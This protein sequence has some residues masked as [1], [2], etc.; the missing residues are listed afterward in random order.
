MED[1]LDITPPDPYS[2]E[3]RNAA[4][5]RL[6][7]SRFFLVFGVASYLGSHENPLPAIL[8]T[9]SNPEL[10][11]KVVYLESAGETSF[12]SSEKGRLLLQLGSR[13]PP[14]S[15]VAK[16]RRV[17]DAIGFLFTYLSHTVWGDLRPYQ[18][19]KEFIT[20]T[21]V[22]V[23]LL[24]GL[25]ALTGTDPSPNKFLSDLNSFFTIAPE[26]TAAVFYLLPFVLQHEDLFNA[27]AFFRSCCSD[28]SFMGDAVRDVV[29]QP[30]WGPENEIQ[31]LALENVVLHSFRTIEA[32]VGEP[33]KRE[34]FHQRLRK[35]NLS[36][37]ER[38][39]FSGRRKHT[40]EN[41][42][43]WL[44]KARDSAA[45]HGKRRRHRP[46]TLLE[47]AE[48]QHLASTVLDRAL[49]TKAES[50]G[51]KG[52]ESEVAFLLEEMLPNNPGW[53]K[54]KKLFKGKRAVDL[55]RTPGGLAKVMRY[56]NRQIDA[57]FRVR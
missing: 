56:R 47:A 17:V 57:I 55:A 14:K 20:G 22:S 7:K 43:H 2:P 53:T 27:C 35:W 38:V 15:R 4:R 13:I 18:I 24:E 42:I 16:A 40:L 31:R 9:C 44:Q 51:R 6:S 11:L 48:A 52:D 8:T 41:R 49:W 36:P 34:L 29:D 19:P 33:G 10:A 5:L 50:L 25:E 32:I 37:Y 3:E 28:F 21:T 12:R 26:P 54:D 23:E 46:F 45:A 1:I 39:G 30:R